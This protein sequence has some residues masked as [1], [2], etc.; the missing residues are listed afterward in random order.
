MI[1][2]KMV[3]LFFAVVLIGVGLLLALGIRAL[4][5]ARAVRRQGYAPQPLPAE[6]LA[7]LQASPPMQKPRAKKA[8]YGMG[9]RWQ[10]TFQSVIALGPVGVRLM[11]LDR[12]SYPWVLCDVNKLHYPQL[13]T[14]LQH[15]PLWVSGHVSK[16]EGDEITLKNARLEFES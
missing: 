13:G 11:L 3:L 15:A 14:L 8:Y 7:A 4:L 6:L 1:T 16:I 9:V 10:V 2:E 12:G 5:R